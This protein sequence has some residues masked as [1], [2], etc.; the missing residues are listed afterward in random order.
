MIIG[1]AGRAGSGKTTIAEGLACRGFLRRKFAA[2]LKDMMRTLL[3]AQG[4]DARTIERMIEG[5]LKTEPTPLLANKTPRW[6][7]Q[8]LGTEWGRVQIGSGFWIE[9]ATR[10]LTSQHDVVFDDVRFANEVEAI[11][12]LGG[13]VICL[14]RD[15]VDETDDHV[16]EKIPPFDHRVM[17]NGSVR[18]TVAEILEI[19]GYSE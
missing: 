4:A 11:T 18:A 17:N 15:D 3:K 2:P 5:D 19:C 7:M 1:L 8:S 16:S 10:G 14:R 9:A 12:A 6:A 13:K